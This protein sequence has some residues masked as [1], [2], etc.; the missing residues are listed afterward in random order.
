MSAL[1]TWC[2]MTVPLLREFSYYMSGLRHTQ[3][4]LAVG[5]GGGWHK[6]L[7]VGSVSLWRRLLAS[8]LWTFCYDKQASVLLQASALPRASTFLGGIQNATSAHGVV[9]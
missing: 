7:V 8:R 9:P 4:R 3:P 1:V 2:T 6:V 5:G